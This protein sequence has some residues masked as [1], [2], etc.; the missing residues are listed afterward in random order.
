MDWSK[1]HD[2]CSECGYDRR[3]E[4]SES[5]P[6]SDAAEPAILPGLDLDDDRT[7]K[8]VEP[9][10]VSTRIQAPEVHRIEGVGVI[11]HGDPPGGS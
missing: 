6:V 1:E 8:V 11:G 2:Y 7:H 5:R 9:S 10:T 3:D 4:G